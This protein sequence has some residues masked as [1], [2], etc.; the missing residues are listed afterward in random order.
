MWARTDMYCDTLW[1]S[2][3]LVRYLESIA[4]QRD[5]K[6]PLLYRAP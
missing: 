6:R 5:Q 2:F 4:A 3:Y 1:V